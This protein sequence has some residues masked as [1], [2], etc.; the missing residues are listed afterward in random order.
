MPTRQVL[1]RILL[2]QA[3]VTDTIDQRDTNKL[4]AY[5]SW[6]A[7]C[8]ITLRGILDILRR[9]NLKSEGLPNFGFLEEWL[10]GKSSIQISII[11]LNKNVTAVISLFEI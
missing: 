1:E 2:I 5:L 7:V 3:S 10:K 8:C 6:Y 4:P 11:Q 9:N